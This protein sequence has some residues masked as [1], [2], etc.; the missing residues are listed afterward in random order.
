[1]FKYFLLK[2]LASL[3]RGFT[4]IELLVVTIIVGVLAAI[5]VPN[6]I[7]QVGKA[8]ETE[9]ASNLAVVSRAQ[10][11]YHFET[12]KF[13]A[14]LASLNQNLSSASGYYSFPDPVIASNSVV[15]HQAIANAPWNTASRNFSI[16]VYYDS[17]VF[18][19]VLCKAIAPTS[20]VTAP[21][22]STDVCSNNGIRIK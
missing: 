15:K 22:T 5:S 20:S 18:S 13:A 3:E 4:L 6:L 14:T 2:K 16:G 1:M 9:A 17:G 11:T 21:D 8:R 7:S 12:K 10:Q 19:T